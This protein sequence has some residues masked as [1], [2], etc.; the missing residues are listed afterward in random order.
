MWTRPESNLHLPHARR[1]LCLMSYE[2]VPVPREQL[3]PR[4]VRTRS[5][6]RTR[7]GAVLSGVPLPLGYPG[8][9]AVDLAGLEP[10]A[11]AVQERRSP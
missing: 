7:T 6:I 2:P 9:M 11:S 3:V 8:K 10:A 4:R 5:A 1:V